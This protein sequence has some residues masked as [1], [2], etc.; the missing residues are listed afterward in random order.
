MRQGDGETRGK[1]V[2]GQ[3]GHFSGWREHRTLPTLRASRRDGASGGVAVARGEALAR[4]EEAGE[5]AWPSWWTERSLVLRASG[6]PLECLAGLSPCPGPF[7][8]VGRGLART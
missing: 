5:G 2:S 8:W 7:S 3:S 1:R 4:N 6:L